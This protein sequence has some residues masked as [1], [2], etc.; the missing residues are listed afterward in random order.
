MESRSLKQV[1]KRQKISVD[2]MWSSIEEILTPWDSVPDKTRMT[3]KQIMK[4]Y[5]IIIEDEELFRMFSQIDKLKK[6][7]D[8]LTKK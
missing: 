7:I 6:S 5:S 8:K 1:S 3:D 4:L 2:Q